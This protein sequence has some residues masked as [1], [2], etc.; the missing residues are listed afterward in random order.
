MQQQLGREVRPDGV[1]GRGRGLGLQRRVR[2]L[3]V[4]QLPGPGGCLGAG[5]LGRLLTAVE[6]LQ[7]DGAGVLNGW[8]LQEDTTNLSTAT[9]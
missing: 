8:G 4:L 9:S 7:G 1:G 6:L 2:G 3:Q 5:V